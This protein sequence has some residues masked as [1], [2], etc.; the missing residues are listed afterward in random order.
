[1]KNNFRFIFPRLM[2]ATVIVGLASFILIT[3]FK[4]L[5]GVLLVGAVVMLMKNLGGRNN[6]GRGRFGQ[7]AHNGISPLSNGN[8]W[9][10][11]ITFNA[12]PVQNQTIVPI[13]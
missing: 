8:P 12:N 5:V 3:L 4:L 13:N 1:M 6:P 11:P 9:E 7:F 2:G 10:N